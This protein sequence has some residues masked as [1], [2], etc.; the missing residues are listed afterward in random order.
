MNKLSKFAMGAALLA[1]VFSLQAQDKYFTRDGYIRFF[2][3]TSVEDIEAKNN[4]VAA[5]L[6][7]DGQ[8]E[9]AVL[10]KSFQFEKAL[11]QEHFNENYVESNTYPKATFKGKVQNMDQVDLKKPGEYP[12]TVKGTMDM[13]GVQKEIEEK[14]TISVEGDAVTLNS[15]FKLKPEDYNIEIPNTVRNNIAEHIE[16]T[17]DCKLAP[18]KK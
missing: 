2:S 12:V 16:V 11:M 13:H 14:G 7:S 8:V 17:V 1:S 9:F 3:S 10:M 15:V 4:N 18:F 5:V 6:A